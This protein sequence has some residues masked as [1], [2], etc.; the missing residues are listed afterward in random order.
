MFPPCSM[1]G[2]NIVE[3]GPVVFR[4]QMVQGIVRYNRGVRLE[5]RLAVRTIFAK[6]QIDKRQCVPAPRCG[7]QTTP[8]SQIQNSVSR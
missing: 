3:I 6:T 4:F 1:C 5:L 8:L 2:S 7:V